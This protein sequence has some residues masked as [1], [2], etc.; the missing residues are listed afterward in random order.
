MVGVD[1]RAV[2]IEEALRL[3]KE[4]SNF[5]FWEAIGAKGLRWGRT[6]GHGLE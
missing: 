3:R 2:G 4:C 6:G 1:G 5:E